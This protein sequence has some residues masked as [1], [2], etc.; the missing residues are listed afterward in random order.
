MES[1]HRIKNISNDKITFSYKDYRN[2]GLKKEM[3]LEPLVFIQRYALHILPK[4]FVRIR[5]YGILS[6]RSKLKCR[7]E[8][9][10]HIINCDAINTKQ[11]HQLFNPKE[12]PCC[13]QQTMRTIMCF[14]RRAPPDNWAELAMLF[15]KT[16]EPLH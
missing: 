11:L 3:E 12:C 7:I 8:I 16:C 4:G 1:N 5:H 2:N 9:N 15:L 14:N 13:K 10:R 6:S